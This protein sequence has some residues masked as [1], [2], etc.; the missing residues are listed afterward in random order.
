MK[1]LRIQQ[2]QTTYHPELMGMSY[3]LGRRH[4]SE[5]VASVLPR[6]LKR[7]MLYCILK[8]LLFLKDNNKISIRVDR[9]F[10]S[11]LRQTKPIPVKHYIY[12]KLS[13]MTT[14]GWLVWF[15]VLNAT[16]N[17]ISVISWIEVSIDEGRNRST[18]RKPPTCGMSSTN[19]IT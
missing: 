13:Q 1:S 2:H 12:Y 7:I 15:M 4:G 16:F 19:F 6:G 9:L 11:E 14:A 18:R 10:V 17:S 5:G 8:C 3:Q